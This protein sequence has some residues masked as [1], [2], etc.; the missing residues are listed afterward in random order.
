MP[1]VELPT[2]PPEVVALWTELLDLADANPAPWLLIGAQMVAVHAWLGD[3]LPPRTSR[4][5]DVLVDV[6][7]RPSGTRELATYLENRGFELQGPS[8][9]GVGHEFRR[10]GVAIDVLAPDNLGMRARLTTL[11][12]AHTVAVPGGT[13]AIQRAERVDVR[14]GDR[15]GSIMI[16]SLLGA[17]IL[18]F[19]AIGVD[20]VPQA[21]KRDVAILL[22]LVSDRDSLASQLASAERRL[23][24]RY[25]EFGDAASRVYDGLDRA[26]EAAATYRRFAAAPA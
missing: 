12:Q 21:Q 14:L 26:R 25:S 22:S 7:T 1:T 17:I 3:A 8:R 13:Q 4:D 6:R 5:G 20:D 15:S 24:A 19:E 16:P 11:H 18:K 10:D 2:A 23:I 9:M